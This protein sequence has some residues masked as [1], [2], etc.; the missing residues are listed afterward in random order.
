MTESILVLSNYFLYYKFF[1]FLQNFVDLAGSEKVSM[2]DPMRT[3]KRDVSAGYFLQF[4]Y[5]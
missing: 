1:F 3:K 2:H 4:Y 5:I